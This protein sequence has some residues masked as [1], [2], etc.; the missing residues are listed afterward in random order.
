[1]KFKTGM[2]F[3]FIPT[4]INYEYNLSSLIKQTNNDLALRRHENNNPI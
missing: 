2:A 1:M 3:Y 4:V